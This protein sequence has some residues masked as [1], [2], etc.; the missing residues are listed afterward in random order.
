METL[1]GGGGGG[2]VEGKGHRCRSRGQLF[3]T[4]SDIHSNS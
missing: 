1:L 3:H 4:S 2:V